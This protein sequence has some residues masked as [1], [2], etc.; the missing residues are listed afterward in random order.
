MWKYGFSSVAGTFHTRS[1]MPGQDACAAE[2]ISDAWGNEVLIAVASDGAGSAL[3]GQVGSR[4]ACQL[5][6][7]RVKAHFASSGDCRGL[8]NGFIEDWVAQFQQFVAT[9]AGEEGL[10][11]QD[12]ACTLLAAV[13]CHEQAAY[14]QIG[15]GAIVASRRDEKDCYHC[16]WWPQQ[17]EYANTTNFLTDAGAVDKIFRRLKSS[18]I[19]EIAIFTDGIQS[20]VLNYRTRSAHSPFF[21]PLFRW[22]R[23]R[24]RGYSQELSNSL[25]AYLSSEKINARTD[26]DRTLVLA[27]RR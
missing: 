6:L 3:Q 5:F 17:G 16:V 24:G 1:S 9:Q 4:M 10:G 12:F 26:D 25:A 11:M 18:S 2:V 23:P 19:D 14:F 27:T 21:S 22:L 8:A 7:E 15:D 13:V 20:L